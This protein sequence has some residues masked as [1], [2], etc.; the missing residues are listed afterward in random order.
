MGPRRRHTFVLSDI[1]LAEAEPN[2]GAWMRWR[3][4]RWF[5]DDDLRR[6]VDVL[7]SSVERD[8]VVDVVFGGDTFEF[9]GPRVV[10]GETRF[11]DPPRTEED[12][13]ATAERILRDHPVFVGALAD[14]VRAGHRVVFVIGNHDAQLAFPAVQA[15]LRSA[16]H[17]HLSEL[18]REEIERRVCVRPWFFQTEDGV[19]VEHGHQYDA[20]CTFRDPLHPFAPDAEEGAR[21]IHP[22]VGSVAFRHL[23]SRMGYFNAYDERS[24]MLS[25]GGYLQHWAKHYLFSGKSLVFTAAAGTLKVAAKVLA[26]RPRE[27]VRDAIREQ[28]SWTRAAFARIH[29]LDRKAVE[30]HA[31]LFA[32]PVDEDPHRMIRDLRADH[33]ICGTLGVFGV[34]LSAFK[35]R[36]G[37]AIAISSVLVAVVSELARPAKGTASEYAN[38][39]AVR[40]R[41][42]EIYGLRAVVFG[43]THVP[44]ESRDGGTL[45]LNTG[46]WASRAPGAD[47]AEKTHR[48]R[49]VVWLHRPADDAHAALEGG[50]HQFDGAAIAVRASHVASPVRDDGELLGAGDLDGLAHSA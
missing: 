38:V 29:G 44:S 41:I 27:G 48:G 28:A 36:T 26:R 39:E 18:D 1:H 17:A 34:L 21:E 25:G 8:D 15:E 19:H 37:L 2:D 16:I 10:D 49:P 13:R 30:R 23:I 3:Q 6:F 32:A 24:F 31:S 50:L 11:D 35:P 42:A 12:S 5:P 43:H 22:T 40:R 9:E 20:Y 47:E 4:A 46:S 7:L 33:V 45:Q 14:L